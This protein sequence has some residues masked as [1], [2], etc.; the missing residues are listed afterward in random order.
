MN[1]YDKIQRPNATKINV[2]KSEKCIFR[3][4]TSIFLVNNKNKNKYLSNIK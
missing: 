2:I 4:Y 3:Y 1:V